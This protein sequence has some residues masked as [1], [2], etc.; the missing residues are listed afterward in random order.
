MVGGAAGD[1]GLWFWPHVM[2]WRA[3]TQSLVLES[4]EMICF[5]TR[6]VSFLRAARLCVSASPQA[7]SLLT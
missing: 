7:G 1:A 6:A 4:N 3:L 2:T 5:A